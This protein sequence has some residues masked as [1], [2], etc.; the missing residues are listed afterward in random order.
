MDA[1]HAAPAPVHAASI[2]GKV[3]GGVAGGETGRARGEHQALL[4]FAE[5]RLFSWASPYFPL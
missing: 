2:G 3:K 1:A 4:S 5:R